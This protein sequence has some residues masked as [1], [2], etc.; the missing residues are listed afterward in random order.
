M[1]PYCSDPKERKSEQFKE[2]MNKGPVLITTILPP[3]EMNMGSILFLWFIYCLI[4]SIFAAYITAH[5]VA[6]GADYIVA[7]RFAGAVSFAGYSLG[8]LQDSIWFRKSWSAT[9]KSMFDG[10]IYALFTAGI[11]GWLWP[12]I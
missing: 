9:F 12:A 10:L 6:P 1:A 8:L 2:K 4:I 11:F 3:G 5:A 7:F